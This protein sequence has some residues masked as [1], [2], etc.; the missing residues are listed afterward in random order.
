M[1]FKIMFLWSSLS[2]YFAQTISS[3]DTEQF[4][5]S[6]I[7]KNGMQDQNIR[8]IF[9]NLKN[10]ALYNYSSFSQEQLAQFEKNFEPSLLIVGGWQ[11]PKYRSVLK[12]SKALRVLAMDNFYR[13]TIK[14]KFGIATSRIYLHRIFD[15]AFV[16]GTAQF[17]FAEMLGFIPDRI[18]AG[19]YCTLP[20]DFNPQKDLIERKHS[21]N[22]PFLFV[23]RLVKEKGIHTLL[24]GYD[25]YR[26]LSLNP[27]DL[28]IYGVGDLDCVTRGKEGVHSLGFASF[29][30]IGDIYQ[31]A[32][33]LVL[34]SEKEQFG[35]VVVEACQYALPIILSKNVGSSVDLLQEYQN[36]FSF[37]SGDFESLAN[38][39]LIF[40]YMIFEQYWSFANV[41]YNLGMKF[42]PEK[43]IESI[44]RMIELRKTII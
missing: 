1:K 15:C 4:E 27:R 31:K 10:C 14:Q 39:L 32:I 28:Q 40:D 2:S 22:S 18:F 41:S 33:A 24:K 37:E 43:F 25:M 26:H 44:W 16:A 23:G 20:G 3:L 5:I 29:E 21:G 6:I 35:M 8:E 11:D 12:N 7:H 19:I 17:E 13:G 38:C 42:T 36:G 9:P 30:E 34:P